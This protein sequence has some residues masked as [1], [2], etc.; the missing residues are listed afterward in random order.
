[1]MDERVADFETKLDRDAARWRVMVSLLAVGV[2][3]AIS[4]AELAFHRSRSPAPKPAAAEV[5]RA[6]VEIHYQPSLDF[7]RPQAVLEKPGL[8]KSFSGACRQD[9]PG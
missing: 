5:V 3:L 1:M 2:L 6:I 7:R 9:L 4:G 8:L